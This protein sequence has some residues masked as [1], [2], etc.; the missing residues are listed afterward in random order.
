MKVQFDAF[1][2]QA[3]A[4]Y[5]ERINVVKRLNGANSKK[6]DLK[7][8]EW[9]LHYVGAMGEFAV[10]KALGCPLSMDIYQGGDPSP[11]TMIGDLSA[12]IKTHSYIGRNLEF[13]ID[14]MDAFNADILIGVQLLSPVL[15]DV[16]GY[17]DKESFKLIAKSKNYGYG[18]RLSIPASALKSITNLYTGKLTCM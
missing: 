10:K 8:S 2:I 14:S 6:H 1:D 16:S 4:M 11:D 9:E 15:C 13:F 3:I 18:D 7:K 12:Q 5:A 17:I